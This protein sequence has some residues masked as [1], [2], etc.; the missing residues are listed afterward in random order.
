MVAVRH[1]LDLYP[2][3]DVFQPHGF[4]RG[5]GRLLELLDVER[6]VPDAQPAA[7]ELQPVKVLGGRI[8]E[9]VP[10]DAATLKTLS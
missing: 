3:V 6:P 4:G 1:A 7:E 8:D 10:Y 5:L 9:L 2:S